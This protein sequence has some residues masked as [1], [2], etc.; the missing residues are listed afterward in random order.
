MGATGR[1]ISI[2]DSS[3]GPGNSPHGKSGVG[4]LVGVGTGVEE[5][6]IVMGDIGLGVSVQL[7][8]V[9]VVGTN[10]GVGELLWLASRAGTPQAV[11]KMDRRQIA[12]RGGLGF[13]WFLITVCFQS[14][15]LSIFT[16]EA[17]SSFQA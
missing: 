7:G 15:G 5:G 16:S 3:I 10:S 17:P 11:S 2:S 9:T 13:I 8:E 1:G 4:V 6:V 14:M 12:M